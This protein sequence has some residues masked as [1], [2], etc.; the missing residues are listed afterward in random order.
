MTRYDLQITDACRS[1][2]L[3]LAC[4]K[5]KLTALGFRA[6]NI[7]LTPYGINTQATI[8][9]YDPEQDGVVPIYT[10]AVTQDGDLS[11]VRRYTRGGEV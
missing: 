9:L 6:A 8:N 2:D 1:I 5:Q 11:P 4:I 7:D 10:V 3:E